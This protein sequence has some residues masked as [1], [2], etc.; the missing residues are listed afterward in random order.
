MAMF[1]G[2]SNSKGQE[3][4][5]SNRNTYDPFEDIGNSDGRTGGVYPL[6]GIYPILFVD[7]IK[8]IVSRKK[9]NVF[10][11]EFDILQSD[12]PE[13][14]A[15]S[16]MAWAAN[17]RHDATAGSVKAFLAAV[18]NCDQSEV[19]AEGSRLACSDKNPCH[20][21]LI[22]LE[23]TQTKTKSNNDFTLCAW[24]PIPDEIQKEAMERRKAAGFVL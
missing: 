15:G 22:R 17:F 3:K 16:R 23:A 13:R 24:R 14:P 2:E 9:D 8:M 7:V 18:M 20:G 5:S 6:P 11:A 1:G 12:V 10:I 19:D 21:R 4:S